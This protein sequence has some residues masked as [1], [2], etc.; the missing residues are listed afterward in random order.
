MLAHLLKIIWK[1]KTRNL[2]LMLE[3]ALAFVLVFAVV[4]FAT[5]SAQ[6]YRAPL[7]FT[8][9]DVWAIQLQVPDYPALQANPAPL[10]Q[11]QRSLKEMPAVAE[12]ALV[13]Y[14]PYSN[15]ANV[16]G[17]SPSPGALRVASQ[18]LQTSDEYAAA[19]GLPLVEG[20]WFTAADG[21][22]DVVPVVV[23][24]RMARAL[25]PDA[26]PGESVIGKSFV[27]DQEA[28]PN[29]KRFRITGVV[30]SYRDGGEFMAPVNFTFMRFNPVPGAHL[31]L[32]VVVK[33]Q[34]GTP[35]A[36]EARLID[37]LKQLRSEWSY[38]IAPL[39]DLR[40]DV[41]RMVLV[42]LGV[43]A[44]I[45]AFLLLMVGFGLFGVLWQN[46]TLRIPEIGLR[47]ALGAQATQIYWQIVAE[48]LLLSSLAMLV[49][50][51]LLVQLP[52]TGL[53]GDALDWPVFGIASAATAALLLAVS[54]LCALYPGWQAS[55]LAPA[56]ALHYE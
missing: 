22:G 52:L 10:E 30:D 34:T 25:F 38:Q 54:L 46:T 48:Q 6:L 21:G 9:Q 17:F 3:I 11:I 14:S 56:A 49:A 33:L 13:S 29:P 45:A 27:Y 1:R 5:R 39:K 40:I 41:L 12:V 50:L 7:G 18:V 32:T 37:R 2:L 28:G 55:R 42:P 23:D 20:R 16:A 31:P 15:S 44:V 53:L 4:A 51:L 35:R 36:F 24:R 8:A 19:L 43:V 47:R 26:S